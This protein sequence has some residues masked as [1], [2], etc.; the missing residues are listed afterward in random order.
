L[1]SFVFDTGA[2][3]LFYADDGRLRPLVDKIHRERDRGLLSSVTLS[4]FYYKTCQRLGRDVA[5]LWS[6]QLS[7]RM[8]IVDADVELSVKAGLEK[9]RNNR[10][11][12]ADSF[13]LALARQ[14]KGLLLTTD[15][16]LAK[17]K[18]VSV[19]FFEV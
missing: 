5:T 9:C 1:T 11:S 3:S 12:L 10:L 15:S 13:A 7:E 2:L 14:V 4:E 8:E 19:R 18:Q 17:S 16:E 6:R